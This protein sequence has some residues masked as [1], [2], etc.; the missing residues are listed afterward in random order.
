MHK[1][2]EIALWSKA[3]RHKSDVG[4]GKGRVVGWDRHSV[5]F[6][7]RSPGMAAKD[8]ITGQC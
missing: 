6:I 7:Y 2:E 8:R 5:T 4:S 1:I 3:L